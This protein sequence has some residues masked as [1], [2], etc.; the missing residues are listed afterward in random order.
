MNDVWHYWS[1]NE[2]HQDDI[3]IYHPYY[4]ISVFINNILFNNLEIYDIYSNFNEQLNEYFYIIKY[5]TILY[6]LIPYESRLLY[7]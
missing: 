6:S 1:L 2:Y 3:E 5:H 7:H 4:Y